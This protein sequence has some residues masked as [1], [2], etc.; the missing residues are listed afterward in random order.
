MS[1]IVGGCDDQILAVLPET[2]YG[3]GA[4]AGPVAVD[5]SA[6]EGLVPSAPHVN[7]AASDAVVHLVH[8]R[9]SALSGVW[10]DAHIAPISA[11]GGRSTGT[12]VSCHVEATDAGVVAPI[13]TNLTQGV[14]V[15]VV[16]EISSVV[17][18]VGVAHISHG[19]RG[20]FDYIS[21]AHGI[22]LRHRVG[23]YVIYS[24]RLHVHHVDFAVLR[25][26]VRGAVVQHGGIGFGAPAEALLL[27][28]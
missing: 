7:S 12:I 6:Q 15:L 20:D 22:A 5:R 13:P 26:V 9:T 1:P 10:S 8:H 3:V 18:V 2:Q 16:V 14:G 28:L 17:I 4:L 11:V 24:S 27:D 19:Q 23:T 25:E 21:I